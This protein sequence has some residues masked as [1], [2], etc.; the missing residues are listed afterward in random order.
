LIFL[1][2]GIIHLCSTFGL[3][4]HDFLPYNETIMSLIGAV[5]FSAYL[6]Y[7]TRLVVSGKHSKYQL[8]E[9][10]YVFGAMTLY[11]DVINIFLYILR[12]L[13]EDSPPEDK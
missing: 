3:L 1:A 11:S 13:G 4:P 12:L 2:Y 8:N 6:A 9:Q 7:H 10:D 5:L